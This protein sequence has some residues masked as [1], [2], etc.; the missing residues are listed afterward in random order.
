MKNIR[1]FEGFLKKNLDVE[2][3]RGILNKLNTE[4]VGV[5]AVYN[6]EIYGDGHTWEY[7]FVI[8]G[9]NIMVKSSEGPARIPGTS[10]PVASD[11]GESYKIFVDNVKL[12][13]GHLL[14]KKIYKRVK[15]LYDTPS[16]ENIEFVKKDAHINF[17]KK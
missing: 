11:G 5:T 9:F 15:W 7:S 17:T 13:I 10:I 3:A 1:T 4:K 8:D 14:A 16:R 12:N 2:T 6:Y